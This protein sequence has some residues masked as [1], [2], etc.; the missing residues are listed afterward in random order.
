MSDKYNKDST[1]STSRRH[2]EVRCAVCGKTGSVIY[3]PRNRV[4]IGSFM[5]FGKVLVNDRWIDYWECL[6]CARKPREAST[7]YLNG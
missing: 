2:L 1:E 5:Y 3:N 6:E 7:R 4:Y